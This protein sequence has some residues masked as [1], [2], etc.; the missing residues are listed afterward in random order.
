M[1]LKLRNYSV[2]TTYRNKIA[3]KLHISCC[4]FNYVF[5]EGVYY[6]IGEIVSNGP[7]ISYSL[8]P[9]SK[10]IVCDDSIIELNGKTLNLKEIK[11]YSCYLNHYSILNNVFS[12]KTILKIISLII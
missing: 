6:F 4:D 9:D 12:C 2:Y 11:K 8:T 5:N 10:T 7:A 1:K 3:D